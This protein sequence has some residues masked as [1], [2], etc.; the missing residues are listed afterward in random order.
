[1]KKALILLC[2]LA[3]YAYAAPKEF[4]MTCH[5]ADSYSVALDNKP[6]KKSIDGMTLAFKLLPN[7]KVLISGNLTNGFEDASPGIWNLTNVGYR[8]VEIGEHYLHV[9][10]IDKDANNAIYTRQSGFGVASLLKGTCN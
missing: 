8:I 10:Q 4:V 5:F 9:V 6:I 1:M 3:N 7:N 2:F